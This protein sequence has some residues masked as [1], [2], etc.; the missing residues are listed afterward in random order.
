MTTDQAVYSVA[1]ELLRELR[2]QRRTRARLLGVGLKN[3]VSGVGPEQIGLFEGERTVGRER[4]RAL[5][6]AVDRLRDRFGESA[7]VPGRI[8]QG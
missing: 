3:L 1:R 2:R 4:Q 6:E 7:V 5:T 8:I